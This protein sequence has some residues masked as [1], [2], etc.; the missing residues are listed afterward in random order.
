MYYVCFCFGHVAGLKQAEELYNYSV[1]VGLIPTVEEIEAP[2][3]L[4]HKKQGQKGK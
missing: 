1:A 2:P 4:R 3:E